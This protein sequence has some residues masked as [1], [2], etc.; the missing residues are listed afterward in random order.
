MDSLKETNMNTDKLTSESNIEY[1]H[2]IAAQIPAEKI[3]NDLM[4]YIKDELRRQKLPLWSHVGAATSHG[5][6]VAS[7]IV[8]RFAP[9]L[10]S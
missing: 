7:A 8:Q 4:R 3:V 1:C 2:R 10:D 6:G 5:S 9:E